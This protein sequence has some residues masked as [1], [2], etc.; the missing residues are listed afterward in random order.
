MNFPSRESLHEVRIADGRLSVWHPVDDEVSVALADI[1]VVAIETDDSGP[2]GSDVRWV[3]R[4]ADATVV[5]PLGATGEDALLDWV[6]SQPGVDNEAII[7]AMGSTTIGR[8][9]V[10]TRP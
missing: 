10:W 6:Q 2:W 9:P 7:E 5:I 1:A 4:T 3:L 8:F